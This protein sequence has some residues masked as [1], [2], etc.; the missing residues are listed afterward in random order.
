MGQPVP[1]LLLEGGAPDADRHQT[2]G[3]L[4][5]LFSSGE[6]WVQVLRPPNKHKA[7][8]RERRPQGCAENH[9][10]RLLKR[11]ALTQL[12]VHSVVRENEKIHK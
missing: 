1:E 11:S 6:R 9:A 2:I 3:N 8:N 4:L 7:E 12:T 5:R 10:N